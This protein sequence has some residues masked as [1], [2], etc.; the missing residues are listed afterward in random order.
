MR[1]LGCCHQTKWHFLYG[2]TW[3]RC[4]WPLHH[5]WQKSLDFNCLFKTSNREEKRSERMCPQS[6][7]E[8]DTLILWWT[9]YCP[10]REFPRAKK[11]KANT[12]DF[13]QFFLSLSCCVLAGS[14]HQ[15]HQPSMEPS[16]DT[17]PGCGPAAALGPT[18]SLQHL[19]RTEN[20]ELSL[21]EGH[22]PHK[23]DQAK[24]LGQNRARDQHHSVEGYEEIV[25]RFLEEVSVL[26]L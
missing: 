12:E 14:P 13:V 8:C 17:L 15:K 20:S 24:L 6:C 1:E 5:L 4:Y 11:L 21:R 22:K 26:I 23:R 18:S 9:H 19:F 7:T 10:Q 2:V 16:Q 25:L 3:V